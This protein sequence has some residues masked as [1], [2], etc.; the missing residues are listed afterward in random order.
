MAGDSGAVAPAS[1]TLATNLADQA[2]DQAMANFLAGEGMAQEDGA[3]RAPL[4]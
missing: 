2:V 3:L 4:R 1:G